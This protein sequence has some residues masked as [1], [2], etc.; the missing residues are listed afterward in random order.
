VA[1]PKIVWLYTELVFQN[2][3]MIEQM[4]GNFIIRQARK[5]DYDVRLVDSW[6]AY[7]W[8]SVETSH[9]ITRTMQS[10]HIE[11]KVNEVLKMALLM[12]HGGLMFRV[13]DTF[14]IEDLRWV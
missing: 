3:K 10:Q 7:E 8:L 13:S 12:E 5:S 14:L 6:S 2:S 1:F 9:R 11:E 4:L